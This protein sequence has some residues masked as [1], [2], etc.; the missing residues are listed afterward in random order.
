M[1]APDRRAKLVRNHPHLS[2]KRQTLRD[3][4]VAE[5]IFLENVASLHPDAEAE[6]AIVAAPYSCAAGD[7]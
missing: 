3:V 7:L 2:V 4:S 6:P 1:S 5:Y